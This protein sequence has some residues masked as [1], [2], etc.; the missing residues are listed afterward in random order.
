MKRIAA[1]CCLSLWGFVSTG[2]GSSKNSATPA[3]EQYLP[4]PS[5]IAFD[6][7]PVDSKEPG[8]K[9]L[10]TY[11]SQGKTARFRIE[12]APSKPPGDKESRS[13]RIQAGKGRLV[14][15]PGSDASVL[16]VDLKNALEA[17]ELPSKVQRIESLPFNFVIF[18]NN[19]SQASGG[20]FSAE[21]P[22]NWT[23]MKLFFGDGEQECEVFLN[24]NPVIK[25]GQF[26]IKDPDYGDELLRQFA[27]VL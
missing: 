16:L 10:A 8:S 17:K 4:E 9:Y 2:C 25:K 11:A 3:L 20:G 1:V 22:G 15:E 14:A 7:E 23:P 12:L 27:K 21:P 24:L 18:G 6:I 26:S 19:N 13:V 5:A